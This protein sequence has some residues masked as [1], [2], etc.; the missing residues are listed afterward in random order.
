[1]G[2]FSTLNT[3]VSGMAAQ[4]NTLTAISQNIANSNTTGYKDVEA[5]FEDV[6]TSA[7]QNSFNGAGVTT[8][9]AYM[10]S[11]QGGF[12]S[13]STD[14]DLAING[15]GFF[16]VEDASGQQF[17]TRDGSFTP[18]ASGNLVNDAGYTLLGL[19]AGATGV[20]N[21]LSDLVP[22][23]VNGP[24][25]AQTPTSLATL[26]AN[27]SSTSAVDAGTLPLANASDS[28]YTYKTSL[29]T[30]DDLGNSVTLDVYFTNTGDVGG[31]PTWEMDVYNAADATNGG[32]PYTNGGVPD[33]PLSSQT[34][35]FDPTTA[36][37]SSVTDNLAGGATTPATAV[38]ITIPG[39]SGESFT[40]DI[41]GM[42]QNSAVT[43]VTTANANGSGSSAATGDVNISATGVVSA[44]Y[45]D[46][47]QK[48]IYNIELAKF[49]NPDGLTPVT[50]NVWQINTQTAG[51]LIPGAPGSAGFGTIKSSTLELSKTDLATELTNMIQA[52]SGYEANSK[53]FQ[54]GTTLLEDLVNLLK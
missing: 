40:L 36:A 52:Q 10:N 26:Y 37:L 28:S 29:Q 41:S 4:T 42:T 23:N 34:L 20:S 9:F 19:P 48:P 15:N 11:E 50:G 16:I 43:G 49:Q 12:T 14:T 2:L 44:L 54:T 7:S 31:N 21:S 32:F 18:D 35:T 17:L 47:T 8:N 6:V 5:E 53:V 33:T 27:L 3:A 46:G 24:A 1:M 39:A 30:Y 45:A 38:P 22:V 51:T 25:S 13:T